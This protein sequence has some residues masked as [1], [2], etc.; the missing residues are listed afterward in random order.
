MKKVVYIILLLFTFTIKCFSQDTVKCTIVSLGII[1]NYHLI[2][3]EDEK[4][5]EYKIV[6]PKVENDC[7][8]IEIAK[9]YLLTLY[10]YNKYMNV[11]SSND[12]YVKYPDG[13]EILIGP[14]MDWGHDLYYA[15]EINGLCYIKKE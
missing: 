2:Y 14:N 13:T 5:N 7:N 8:N 11:I 3:A 15:V 6:S 12:E 10:G 9:E 4:E 1:G